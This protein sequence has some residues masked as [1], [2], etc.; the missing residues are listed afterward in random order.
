MKNRKYLRAILCGALVLM[1]FKLVPPTPIKVYLIGDSTVC[2]YTAK[3]F[4]I[5][6]WGMPFANYFDASVTIDNRARG[7]RSTR[8]FLEENLWKPV[9]DSLKAG[10]YVFMQFGHN[11]EAKE[12]QFAARY[13]PVPDYKKNLIKFITETRAKNAI[14]ILVTP[15]G[16]RS[17]DKDGNIKETHI[18]Y[19][20]AVFEVGD[21]YK[22]PVIDLDKRSRELYQKMG[23]DRSKL[24]FMEL[25]SA[26]HPNYPLGRH[27]NT[28]F[29]EF[30][31]RKLAEIV[32]NELKAQRIELADRIVKGTNAA[33]VNPQAK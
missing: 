3:Q 5:N 30:G 25:D 18:E 2:L 9:A 10:D 16:R 27:D 32:L 33:T 11:D 6:G 23:P 13:T 26:E 29:T 7:G 17:F 22:V 31:A 15:V 14:P 4:P 1:S 8:T 24:L 19:S 12:P 28:H 20:K 21:E